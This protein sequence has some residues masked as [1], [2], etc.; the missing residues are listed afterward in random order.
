MANSG[1]GII[2]VKLTKLL[3][4]M[5]GIERT[6]KEGTFKFAFKHESADVSLMNAR[7]EAELTV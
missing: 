7:L 1:S 4:P 2:Y 6:G 5:G 3:H